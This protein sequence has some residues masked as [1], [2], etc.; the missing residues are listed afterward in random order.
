[1]VAI[2]VYL[3]ILALPVWRAQARGTLL[4]EWN[5]FRM[6]LPLG[7]NLNY[8]ASLEN[9]K[10]IGNIS[11][12]VLVDTGYAPSNPPEW[13]VNLQ[14][15]VVLVSVSAADLQD[16]PSPETLDLL[17]GYTFLRTNRNGWMVD[18]AEHGW[19]T[20]VGGGG[21]IITPHQFRRRWFPCILSILGLI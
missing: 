2:G 5:S 4:V 15:Q 12:L 3:L 7:I 19:E 18:R 17:R 21:E 16:L 11:A 13:I 1:V 9:G 20:D 6:L 8:I 14:S 10:A